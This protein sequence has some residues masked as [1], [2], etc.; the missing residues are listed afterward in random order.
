MLFGFLLGP[1]C[2]L[3]CLN[4]SLIISCPQ[5]ISNS[6]ALNNIR[7][8]VH[9]YDDEGPMISIKVDDLKMAAHLLIS[10]N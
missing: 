4:I 9:G 1:L 5:T 3:S 6:L 2:G 8:M 7:N 10:E